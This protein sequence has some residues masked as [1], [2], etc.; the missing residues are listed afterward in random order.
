MILLQKRWWYNLTE[1]L[2]WMFYNLLLIQPIYLIW[3]PGQFVSNKEQTIGIL[4]HTVVFS[5]LIFMTRLS[6]VNKSYRNARYKAYSLFIG[7][8][9]CLCFV[10]SVNENPTTN[11][12]LLF[13]SFLQFI[14]YIEIF[15]LSNYIWEIKPPWRGFYVLRISAVTLIAL[16][17]FSAISILFIH[18]MKNDIFVLFFLL[19]VFLILISFS[20][21]AHLLQCI[22][23]RIGIICFCLGL[24]IIISISHH[25]YSGLIIQVPIFIG[26]H[27]YVFKRLLPL[28]LI[29]ISILNENFFTVKKLSVNNNKRRKLLLILILIW[30]IV[31]LLFTLFTHIFPAIISPNKFIQ[32]VF[33]AKNAYSLLGGL[34]LLFISLIVFPSIF[35]IIRKMIKHRIVHDKRKN[36]TS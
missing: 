14:Y 25:W 2:K 31:M 22:K 16:Y 12:L 15:A 20:L 27:L 8:V 13:T 18:L 4:V 36:I 5:L 11:F 17:L 30:F 1:T 23:Y 6:I 35:F 19:F 33:Y 24:M 3:H 21:S 34:L 28:Q 9:L 29:N 26:V 10:S 7:Y 32:S